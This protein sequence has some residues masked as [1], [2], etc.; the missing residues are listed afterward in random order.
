M[1]YDE[2]MV[3]ANEFQ[4]E[5]TALSNEIKISSHMLE[6]FADL[7]QN[8]E[9]EQFLKEYNAYAVQ[10]PGLEVVST[11]FAV[12]GK[13]VEWILKVIWHIL[14]FIGRILAWI[15]GI[16]SDSGSGGG[17]V[18][19]ATKSLAATV[20]TNKLPIDD[21]KDEKVREYIS[22]YLDKTRNTSDKAVADKAKQLGISSEKI[23]QIHDRLKE[24][25][26]INI[27]PAMMKAFKDIGYVEFVLDKDAIK[28]ETEAVEALGDLIT[29]YTEF[30][31]RCIGSATHISKKEN[32][33][34]KDNKVISDKIPSEVKDFLK[35]YKDRSD[36]LYDSFGLKPNTNRTVY[37]VDSVVGSVAASSTVKPKGINKFMPVIGSIESKKKT[38]PSKGPSLDKV[39]K[40]DYGQANA[41]MSSIDKAVSAVGDVKDE[42]SPAALIN[43]ASA[44]IEILKDEIAKKEIYDL[45][46]KDKEV[47]AILKYLAS[48]STLP[49]SEFVGDARKLLTVKSFTKPFAALS[50]ILSGPDNILVTMGKVKAALA[51]NG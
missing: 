50:K 1:T 45:G 46:D 6:L 28:K 43:N 10:T 23:A 35:E 37:V 51:A 32:W 4:L 30:L 39:V 21:I 49:D 44:L 20:K 12:I 27:S 22:F 40:I 25:H 3:I 17:S 33:E 16:G 48:S 24:K 5:S 18:S 34:F 15:L 13:V 36:A 11:V 14:S 2:N 38:W 31:V 26:N 7:E 42:K 41:L 29:N 19:T 8:E 47:N 9:P